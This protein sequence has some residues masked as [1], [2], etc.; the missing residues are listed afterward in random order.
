MK[1]LPVLGERNLDGSPADFAL[2]MVLN[3]GTPAMWFREFGAL[4]QFGQ[5][6]GMLCP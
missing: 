4:I 5:Q 6:I 2:S 1:G 3:V